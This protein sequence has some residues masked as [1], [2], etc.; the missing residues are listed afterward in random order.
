MLKFED[1][2]INGSG[3]AFEL[4]SEYAVLGEAV[5]RKIK[6][7]M[8]DDLAEDLFQFMNGEVI[9]MSRE[10][11]SRHIEEVDPEKTAMEMFAEILGVKRPQ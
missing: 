6:E 9:K 11:E 3:N 5:L 7:V 2:M 1:G 4:L 8:P 10:E